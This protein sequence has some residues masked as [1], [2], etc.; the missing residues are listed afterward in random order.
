ML[1]HPDKIM[2]IVAHQDD[3]TIGCGGTLHK[4]ASL[5]SNVDIT[6]VTD[7]KTGIDQRDL[8]DSNSIK[9]VRMQEAAKASEI[10]IGVN[11]I[12]TMGEECQQ[13]SYDSQ[14]IFHKIISRIRK[15]KPSIILTHSPQD[16]HRD[17]IAISRLVIEAAWKA[18]ENIHSELGPMHRVDDV[19]GIEILDLH[20]SP[21]FVVELS[22]KDYRAKVDAM[23]VYLSQ[24]QVVSGIGRSIEGL[25][26]VRGY[27][28]GCDYGEA[29]KRISKVPVRL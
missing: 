1:A 13:V 22:D 23:D 26:M 9:S 5:G 16:K 21:D 19:W 24:E 10:L 3:E 17:H 2:V 28:I 15:C 20:D 27:E 12:Y 14:Q 4:W 29:F 18:N 8:F 6:F 11:N 7:G 25:A